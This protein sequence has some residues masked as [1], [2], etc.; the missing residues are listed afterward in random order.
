[1]LSLI[2]FYKK[3]NYKII[4]NKNKFKFNHIFSIKNFYNN[5]IKKLIGNM[6]DGNKDI[7]GSKNKNKTI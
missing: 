5:L 7:N 1:M 6:L 2:I 4:S 3:K